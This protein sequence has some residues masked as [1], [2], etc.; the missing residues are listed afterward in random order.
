[1]LNIH[2]M[3]FQITLIKRLSANG[4]EAVTQQEPLPMKSVMLLGWNMILIIQIA[5]IGKDVRVLASTASWTTP[6]MKTNGRLVV[7]KRLEIFTIE[8]CL[9]KD[10]SACKKTAVSITLNSLF[11]NQNNI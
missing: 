4:L 9:R 11:L 3:T 8:S 1:M 2:Y 10:F 7:P 6:G 5:Q